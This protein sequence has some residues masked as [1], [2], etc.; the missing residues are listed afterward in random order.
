[1]SAICIYVKKR[2]EDWQSSNSQFL[3]NATNNAKPGEFLGDKVE[4]VR[5]WAVG[6]TDRVL[7]PLLASMQMVVKDVLRYGKKERKKEGDDLIFLSLFEGLPLL[8]LSLARHVRC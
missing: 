2:W 6:E 8:H 4:L 7:L 5:K 1:M 3:V